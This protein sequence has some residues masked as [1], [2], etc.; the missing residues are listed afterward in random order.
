MTERP[1]LVLTAPGDGEI[2]FLSEL[3]HPATIMVGDTAQDFAGAT[4]NA[5][6]SS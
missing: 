1:L 2:F 4:D 6:K 5:E 3:H